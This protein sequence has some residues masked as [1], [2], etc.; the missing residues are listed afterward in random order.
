MLYLLWDA[1]HLILLQKIEKGKAF[2]SLENWDWEEKKQHMISKIMH[3]NWQTNCI[4]IENMRFVP[5]KRTQ[6]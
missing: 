2:I 6:K 3:N 5:L 1:C 4:K